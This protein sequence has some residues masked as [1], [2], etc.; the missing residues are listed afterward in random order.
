MSGLSLFAYQAGSSASGSDR[1]LQALFDGTSLG[2]R[3][4]LVVLGF[5]IIY[6]ATGIINFAQGGF[7]LIGAY[8]TYNAMETWGVPFYPAIVVS[9]ALTALLG[10]LMQRS[11]LQ[12]VFRESAGAVAWLL[13]WAIASYHEQGS[14]ASFLIGLVVGAIVFVLVRKVELRSGGGKLN[15][16]PIFGAVMVTIGL[17]FVIEEIVPAVWGVND[18]TLKDPWGIGAFRPGGL[19]IGHDKLWGIGFA[20]AALLLFVLVDR[21][22]KVGI[23]MRAIH[24]DQE[25]AVA[26]GIPTGLAYAVAW[27]LAGAVA[28]L[29]GT[30]EASGP[31]FSG[32][33]VVIAFLAFPAMI[34]GGFDSPLGAVIGGIVIGIAQSMFLTYQPDWLGPG[35]DRVGIF[36]VMIVVL[37]V[38]PYGLFGTPEVRRV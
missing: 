10:V 28:A 30:I 13:A 35:F 9:M 29:A 36:I 21:Y 26:Q 11:I 7:V 17:L 16:L 34:L 2:A 25:A 4:A 5:V 23:A 37:M 15:E 1:F 31:N 12:L 6:R 32:A 18:L 33:L 3:Y 38:R 14:W 24:F 8:L 27:G 20:A 22:T 19:T